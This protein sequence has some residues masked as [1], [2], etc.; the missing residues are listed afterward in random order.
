MKR[1]I[2]DID[3]TIASKFDSSY[4]NCL[5]NKEV[6]NKLINYKN[7]GYEIVFYTSRN[8]K[9]FDSNIG[10]IIANTVP[11][12]VAWLNKHNIPFDEIHIGKPWCGDEGFYVDDKAIRPEEFVNLSRSEIKDLLKI[13]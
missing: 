1:L 10:K 8:M 12:I 9:T 3:G 7:D 13:K 4:E 5:P 11:I 2:L 6:V